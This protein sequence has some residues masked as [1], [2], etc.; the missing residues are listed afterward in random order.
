MKTILIVDDEYDIVLA[1]EMLFSDEGY[2]VA[3]ASNGKEALVRM[4]E[5]SPDLILL[6][7]MMPVLTGLEVLK[8]MRAKPDFGNTPVILMSA[9]PVHAKQQDYG[10][11]EFITKPL[12]V[13]MVL[14]LVERLIRKK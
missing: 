12:N 8:V 2:K 4:A 10:W 3:T 6:D 7:V 9:V 1:L 14:S 5:V 11:N 13:D